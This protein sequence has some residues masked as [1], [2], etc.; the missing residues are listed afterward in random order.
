MVGPSWGAAFRKLSTRRTDYL[1]VLA[2]RFLIFWTAPSQFLAKISRE[3]D[4]HAAHFRAPSACAS[5]SREKR[6]GPERRE[7]FLSLIQDHREPRRHRSLEFGG[8]RAG[9][10]PWGSQLGPRYAASDTL[11][12]PQ[13]SRLQEGNRSPLAWA[14]SRREP[15][16]VPIGRSHALGCEP[17]DRQRLLGRFTIA[18]FTRA[19]ETAPDSIGFASERVSRGGA[20]AGS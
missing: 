15:R 19:S 20:R 4:A 14:Q 3:A 13:S 2:R 6:T 12:S 10:C 16:R 11:D 5:T 7:S 18:S 1:R 17:C 8:F 9:P